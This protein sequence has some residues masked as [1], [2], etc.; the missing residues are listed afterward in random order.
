MSIVILTWL[1]TNTILMFLIASLK[2]GISTPKIIRVAITI[3]CPALILTTR[4]ST[5]V[6]ENSREV[7]KFAIRL[8]NLLDRLRGSYK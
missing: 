8:I 3:I 5:I 1:V 4:M 2:Q 7:D 6:K